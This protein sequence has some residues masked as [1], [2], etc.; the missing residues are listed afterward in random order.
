MKIIICIGLIVSCW[1]LLAGPGHG[2]SHSHGHSHT[3]RTVTRE[4][5]IDI[6]KSHIKRLIKENKIDASWEKATHHS[7]ERVSNEWKVIFDNQNGVK[8]K[9]LYFFLK[10]TG[11]FVAANFTG[12]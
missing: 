9:K 8:G 3:K 6:G 5:T 4:K 2:H 12:K 11:D 1:S 7:T 10:L